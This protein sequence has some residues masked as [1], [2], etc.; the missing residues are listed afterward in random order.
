MPFPRSS[1]ILLHPTSLPGRYGIGDVGPVAYQFVDFLRDS[2]QQ[3]WQILPFGPTGFG[4]SPYLSYSAMAGNPLFISPDLLLEE[5]LLT[6]QDLVNTPL[7]PVEQVDFD[8]VKAFKWDLFNKACQNFKKTLTEQ[9]NEFEEFCRNKS[10]WL[11]DY[12]LFMAIKEA[13]DGESWH[14]WDNDIAR[15]Q[16]EAIQQWRDKLAD[17]IFFHK[18]LQFE[19]F[20]QWSKLKQYANEQGIQIFGDV[21][22]YVAHDSADVWSHPDIFCLDGETGEA[23]LMA[24]VPPDYFS[25]T[26]QLWGNPVYNWERVQQNGFNW[27]LQ[28]VQS[29]LDCVDIMRIDHFRGLQAFWAV[30]QG[31]TT[32]VNGYWIEAP[33]EALFNLLNEKLGQLPIIAE[34]LGLIT[35]EVEALRDKFELPGMKILQFAFDSGSGNPYLPYNYSTPNWVAYTGTHDNDT[36]V[37]WFSQRSLQAQARVMSY[38]GGTMGH[39]IHWDLI[40]VA[41]ASVANQAILP[42]QDVLGLGSEA[43]MNQPSTSEGNWSWR[44]LP[45]AITDEIRDRLRS[46][47][48]T[49]GRLPR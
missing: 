36:T 47:T 9:E 16:P 10:Y 11:D 31:E 8:G 15:R 25:A 27:W 44:F 33:G 20:R 43:K 49:Y 39:G 48:E 18:F 30:P 5:E 4:N 1:G 26:G 13:H 28:R 12:A 37:G 2:G 23:S 41:L 7:F 34:D 24:G 17:Q 14:K 40:Q 19:F 42:L 46:L 45:G 32:A 3:L 35:P 38:V 29:I 22:I 6:S 21:A